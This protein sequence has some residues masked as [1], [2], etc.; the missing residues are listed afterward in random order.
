MKCPNC[1]KIATGKVC[2]YCH[3]ELPF[4]EHIVSLKQF[5]AEF[6]YIVDRIL[7]PPAKVMF[8]LWTLC[9]ISEVTSDNTNS[10]SGNII[11][12]LFGYLFICGIADLI[13][14]CKKKRYLAYK[15]KITQKHANR[16]KKIMDNYYPYKNL[17]DEAHVLADIANTTT[18]E[19]V[20]NSSYNRLID[21]FT[22]LKKYEF[23]GVFTN[24][25]TEDLNN[26]LYGR[27]AATKKFHERIN[28]IYPS[29]PTS[30]YSKVMTNTQHIHA[31]ISP[32]YV[33]QDNFVQV[34][35]ST[36]KNV[37]PYFIDAAR[38][39]IPKEKASIG[40]LQRYFKLGFNR[41]AILMDQL[42]DAGIVGP[43]EGIE[44]R[45]IIMTLNQFEQYLKDDSFHFSS[46]KLNIYSNTADNTAERITH[47][48][49]KY[50][51]MDG[52]DFEYFC[53]DLLQKNGF[54]NVEVTRG[55]GDQGIDI[56]A[57]KEGVKYGIQCKCYSQNIGNKAVQEAF[58]GKAF[59]DCHVAAVLTNQY[60]TR[61]AK[62]LA[63]HNGVLLWDRDKLDYF[64]RNSSTI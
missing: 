30:P 23:L 3:T 34:I 4:D 39:L 29:A 37:D 7:F 43:E 31:N 56:I 54:S 32:T 55:S 47:Y 51:Y 24:S 9:W 63:E 44:P 45:R 53:A 46:N 28:K 40:M 27:E 42:E 16:I 1:G 13:Y 33:T 12:T 48:N 10:I 6:V 57:Y 19:N 36:L 18:D 64:I 8:I 41:A 38:L 21:I 61:S 62:E 59:Y 58:A 17:L 26:L 22:E 20:F 14:R 35:P 49:N 2:K 15:L 11:A 60:F 52:H 25:P 5:I 50:D